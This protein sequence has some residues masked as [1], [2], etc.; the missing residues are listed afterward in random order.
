MN[1]L[2]NILTESMKEHSHLESQ[3][4]LRQLHLNVVGV[5]P[6]GYP[7]LDISSSLSNGIIIIYNIT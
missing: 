7:H 5:H 6:P 1:K 3:S 4:I 2:N